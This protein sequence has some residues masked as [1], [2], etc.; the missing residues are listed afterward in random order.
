VSGRRRPASGVGVDYLDAAD[1]RLLRDV[2]AEMADAARRAGP[3]LG[4]R[5]GRIDCCLGPFPVNL[6]DARRLQ[7]GVAA[8]A[9]RDRLRA[10]AVR[11]RAEDAVARLSPDYP[12]D[13]GSGL[14]GHEEDAQEGFLGRHDTEPCPVLDPKTGRC[15]LYEWRPLACRTMGPP[16]RI[17]TADLPACRF[18]FGVGA[19]ADVERCRAR[20]DPDGQEDRILSDLE[21]RLGVHGETLIAFAVVGRPPVA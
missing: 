8:L 21:A 19:A 17:G 1:A 7:R 9:R 2:D 15:D 10:G 18:C 14:L 20:P 6:L 4:C 5:P 11:R 3:L 16:V 12:G 13:P